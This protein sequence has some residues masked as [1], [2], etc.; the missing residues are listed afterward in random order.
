MDLEARLRQSGDEHA[1][2]DG[3]AG[4]GGSNEGGPHGVRRD[5]RVSAA[6]VTAARTYGNLTG[7]EL[8][9]RFLN[10]QHWPTRNL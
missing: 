4:A 9:H 10:D 2:G 8:S 1:Q 6:A 7:R 3:L 5:P